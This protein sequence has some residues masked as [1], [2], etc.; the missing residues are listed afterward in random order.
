ME[1]GVIYKKVTI[2]KGGKGISQSKVE[3]GSTASYKY[4]YQ[5]KTGDVVYGMDMRSGSIG[6]IDESADDCFVSKEYPILNI[7]ENAPINE[8]YLILLLTSKEF[9]QVFNFW[10]SGSTRLQ[11]HPEMFLKMKLPFP[12]IEIQNELSLAYKKSI[13]LKVKSIAFNHIGVHQFRNK[14][15]AEQ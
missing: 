8:Y 2:H 1:R 3:N 6:L 14:V 12:S 13:D 10:V 4:L 7:K 11:L 5:V 9:Y 15:F